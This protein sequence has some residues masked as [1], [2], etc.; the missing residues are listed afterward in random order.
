MADR[1]NTRVLLDKRPHGEPMD[2]DFKIETVPVT[3]PGEGELLLK[4]LWLSLDPYMR[5]RMNDRKSYAPP[6]ELG[7]VMVGETVCQVVVSKSDDFTA[8]DIVVAQVGWQSYATMAADP[9]VVRK[10]DPALGPISTALHVLGMTGRTAYFGLL[11]IG[12]PKPGETVVVAAASG[13]V[14]SI[15]GQVAKIKGCRAVGIAG[16]KEKCDYVLNELGFDAVIDRKAGNMAA[17]LKAACP[18]G[19]DVY[20]ENVGGEVLQAVVPLLNSGARAP[21]CGYI[22]QYNKKTVA[23]VESPLDVLG[24]LPNP[25]VHRFFLQFEWIAEFKQ[26]MLE[27]SGWIKE[28]KIKYRES[29]VEGIENAPATF[30]GLLQGRNFGKQLIKVANPD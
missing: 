20:F 7:A 15:V 18:D 2:D 29:V 17:D 27:M 13:A 23:D 22:S 26:A 14:G 8:G 28:G 5:G 12:E 25:P 9:A 30:R 16:G 19:I 6:V 1:Q 11:R 3:E 21:I 4:T 10:V 24:S